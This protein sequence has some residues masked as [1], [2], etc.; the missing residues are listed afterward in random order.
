MIPHSSRRS[1]DAAAVAVTEF[2]T[3]P[4]TGKL[5][6]GRLHSA[7]DS[8]SRLLVL[9]GIENSCHP[10]AWHSRPAHADS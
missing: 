7:I 8:G 2:S 5:A 6:G 10:G 3:A 4:V 9:Y 1:I